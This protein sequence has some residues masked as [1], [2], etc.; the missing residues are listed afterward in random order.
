LALITISN[1]GITLVQA[2]QYPVVPNSLKIT[3]INSNNVNQM[4]CVSINK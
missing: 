2:A 1:A 4:F 3:T